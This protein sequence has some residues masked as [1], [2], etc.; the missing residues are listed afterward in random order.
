MIGNRLSLLLLMLV[1]I[2]GAL[3]TWQ[4]QSR[5]AAP[6]RVIPSVAADGAALQQSHHGI[7][8]QI[9]P[10]EELAQTRQRPLFALT[11]RPSP[12]EKVVPAPAPV[13]EESAPPTVLAIE[14]SAVV[15]QP[16]R[17][18]ALFRSAAQGALLRAEIGQS[19]D[20]WLVREIRADGVSLIRGEE[21]Q[22][23]LLRTF[24]APVRKAAVARSPTA[25]RAA[26][27]ASSKATADAK[28]RPRRA[29]RGPRRRS[30][31]RSQAVA[32]RE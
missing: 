28:Q 18:F 11:R 7:A 13:K 26:K 12:I 30:I 17:Q 22:E 3:A 16:E 4:W 10:L 8:V 6:S 32:P 2:F 25:T 19:V 31:A 27:R 15:L 1:L 24:K 29:L 20:G 9:P 23:L 14:L 21:H 5:R